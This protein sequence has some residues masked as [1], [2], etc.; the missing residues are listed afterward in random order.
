MFSARQTF[1][2]PASAG[3]TV[4]VTGGTLTT[5]GDYSIRTFNTSGTLGITG[6]SLELEY[7][8][9][10]GGGAGSRDGVSGTTGGGGGAGGY[11]TA[12]DTFIA[13]SYT[14]TIGAGGTI[15][16]ST[17]FG[18]NGSNTVLGSITST[19][20]GRGAPTFTSGASGGSGGGGGAYST[21]GSGTAGQGNNGG[22]GNNSNLG[23]GGGGAGGAGSPGTAGVG[24]SS[25][26]SGTSVTRGIGGGL[27]AANGS[28]NTGS[29]G[30]GI[31]GGAPFKAGDGGSG[32]VIVRYLTADAA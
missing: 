24:L 4:T 23:G 12:T 30:G 25:S 31:G 13:D 9:I 32:V 22:N 21:G 7:L 27:N 16:S 19:G 2:P 14:V 20:G 1:F 28:V 8:V 26:I 5:D 3:P 15:A 18:T 10:A 11:R 29:G 6:G 17:A